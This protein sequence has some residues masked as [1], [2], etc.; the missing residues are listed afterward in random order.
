[1]ATNSIDKALSIKP[2]FPAL[3]LSVFIWTVVSMYMQLINGEKPAIVN[4]FPGAT[5][6]EAAFTIIAAFALVLCIYN[7]LYYAVLEFFEHS[8]SISPNTPVQV[9]ILEFVVRF[10]LVSA[11]ALKI[12]KYEVFDS[13]FVFAGTIGLLLLLWLMILR[14]QNIGSFSP[15]DSIGSFVVMALAFIASY[16]LT[17]PAAQS[18]FAVWLLAIALI[19]TI[20]FGAMV[21][22]LAARFGRRFF[23][24]SMRFITQWP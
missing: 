10:L 14:S 16:L 5:N 7:I 13:L 19:L 18:E 8:E 4:S 9:L 15:L 21:M 22:Y 3:Y 17:E 24:L 23:A 1:L 12:M 6:Q 11:V 2:V 20:A